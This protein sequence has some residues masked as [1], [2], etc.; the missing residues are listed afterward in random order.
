MYNSILTVYKQ[1][2]YIELNYLKT[3]AENKMSKCIR[4]LYTFILIRNYLHFMNYSI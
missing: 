3:E 2:S 1:Y 4:S